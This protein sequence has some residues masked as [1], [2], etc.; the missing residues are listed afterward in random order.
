[1]SMSA[2][3]YYESIIENLILND[4]RVKLN[5]NRRGECDS[6][7]CIVGKHIFIRC[8]SPPFINLI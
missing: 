3:K 8:R 7:F 1:M 6:F 5:S 4:K 2:E